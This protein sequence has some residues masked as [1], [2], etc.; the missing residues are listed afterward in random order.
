MIRLPNLTA[1]E[2]ARALK[3][4]GFV[5][6]GQRGSHLF[7]WHD[8]KVAGTSVPMHPGDLRRSLLKQIIKQADLSEEEFRKYL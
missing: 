3:R 1:R 4:A 8:G 5:E 7:L 6:D 2:V